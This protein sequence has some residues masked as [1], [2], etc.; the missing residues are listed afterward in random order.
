MGEKKVIRIKNV[1]NFELFAHTISNCVSLSLSLPIE[2][3][4]PFGGY[5]A[6]DGEGMNAGANH[7]VNKA[8]QNEFI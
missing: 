3:L 8:N 2:Y 1:L 5:D 7:N 6:C 4:P